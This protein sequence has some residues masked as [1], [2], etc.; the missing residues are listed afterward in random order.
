LPV[1]ELKMK[2]KDLASLERMSFGRETLP[3][4]F[5]AGGVVYTNVKVRFR[6]DWARTWPKKP[7]KIF[8]DHGQPFEGQ[9]CLN[10]NSGWRDPAFV[11]EPLAYHVYAACGV[12]SPRSRMVRLDLN[13]QPAAIVG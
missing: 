7:L 2:P 12:P 5:L 10:L 3:A 9:R 6:G 11:R 8:F 4:T 13:G 1:Y